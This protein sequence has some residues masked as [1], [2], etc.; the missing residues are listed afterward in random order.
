[1]P[2]HPR[3]V[4]SVGDVGRVPRVGPRQANEHE[5]AQLPRVQRGLHVV[6][7]IVHGLADLGRRPGDAHAFLLHQRP[8]ALSEAEV[9]DLQARKIP[10]EHEDVL[11]ADVAVSEV[12]RVDELEG[13]GHLL[14]DPL[15]PRL[16]Q[17]A[18]VH[19]GRQ[20]ALRGQLLREDV[21]GGGVVGGVVAVDDVR[22]RT[23]EV[24]VM[25]LPEKLPF[26]A[27]LLVDALEG[28]RQ[29]GV[30]GDGRVHL[31]V[32]AFGQ[33]LDVRELSVDVQPGQL[34]R[35]DVVKAPPL[36]TNFICRRT[37]TT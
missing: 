20:V 4:V 14:R 17:A 3:V 32:P 16:P 23:Q 15:R 6:P 33:K 5:D 18:L 10:L 31:R 28:E 19:E 8:D 35:S 7:F 1:M 9:G 37:T 13:E 12:L 11:E 2:R 29:A 24:V 25:E 22:V 30:D 36:P 27:G 21:A 26:A 34:E